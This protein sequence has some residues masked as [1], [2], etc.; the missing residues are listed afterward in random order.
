MVYC[1]NCGEEIPEDAYFCHKCGHRTEKGSEE[2]ASYPRLGRYGWHR[3]EDYRR[4]V[5]E[6]TKPLGGAVTADR[7]FFGVENINGPIQVST[8]DK[9][10]YGIEL[11]IKAGGYTE[12]EA[13]EN[14]KALKVDLEDQVVEGQQR[15]NLKFDYPHERRW[16]SIA[17]DVNLPEGA[18]TDLDVTSKNGGITL[19]RLKGGTME[20][21]T[22]NGK[23]TLGEISAAKISLKTSNGKVTLEDV[24]S[25][26]IDLR[27]SNGRVTLDDVSAPRMTGKTS[28]GRIEGNLDSQEASLSTS[29]GKIDLTLPCKTSGEYELHS[30]NGRITLEVSGEPNVGYDLDLRTSMSH[31]AV[32]LPDLEYTRNKKTHKVAKTR[33]YEDK[34]AKVTIEAH[35]SH[36][37]IQVKS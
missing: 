27:T 13:E 6:E 36:G 24:S 37:K 34:D 1:T 30:S 33:G 7:V 2:G 11:F 4:F 32:D 25:E 17:I 19:G 3:G 35:T 10:E 12:E 29:N 22:N 28:N 20:A 31:I 5:A 9:A 18:E 8:W 26:V 16:Y 14:L 21:T 23:I 15:L